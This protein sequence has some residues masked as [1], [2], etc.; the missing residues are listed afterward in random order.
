[1]WL[2]SRENTKTPTIMRRRKEFN[3]LNCSNTVLTAIVFY[4]LL[5]GKWNCLQNSLIFMNFKIST[6]AKDLP[7]TV[8]TETDS[9]LSTT[10][11]TKDHFNM[12][13]TMPN[14]NVSTSTSMISS[15]IPS[16]TLSTT[17][18]TSPQFRTSSPMDT[19]TDQLVTMPSY[20]AVV[21]TLPP[22]DTSMQSTRQFDNI[23]NNIMSSS[24]DNTR[25]SSSNISFHVR[26][27]TM[28]PCKNCSCFMRTHITV[29]AY[30]EINCETIIN[31]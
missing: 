23:N 20:A 1:M 19:T 28:K 18:P 29:E 3:I 17:F 24:H 25:N 9:Q 30:W 27:T 15:S 7:I 14:K 11:P 4:S 31:S 8:V 26:F 12:S 10:E 22:N 2:F 5:I 6:D 13:M 16:T 21:A